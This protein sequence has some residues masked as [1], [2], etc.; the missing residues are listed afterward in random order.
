MMTVERRIT[1]SELG[2]DPKKFE[3]QFMYGGIRPGKDGRVSL[4]HIFEH[5]G[6]KYACPKSD[7]VWGAACY[8]FSELLTPEEFAQRHPEL[9]TYDTYDEVPNF[10]SGR[11]EGTA[12]LC[13]QRQATLGHDCGLLI[14]HKGKKYRLCPYVPGMQICTDDYEA[15]KKEYDAWVADGRPSY[16]VWVGDYSGTYGWSCAGHPRTEEE[17]LTLYNHHSQIG[18]TKSYPWAQKDKSLPPVVLLNPDGHIVS[19]HF[20]ADCDIPKF[21]QGMEY[22]MGFSAWTPQLQAEFMSQLKTEVAAVV[23]TELQKMVDEGTVEQLQPNPAE[24][25]GSAG[26]TDL[27]RQNGGDLSAV[28]REPVFGGINA[29]GWPNPLREA[30]E[31]RGEEVLDVAH[32]ETLNELIAYRTEL[33]AAEKLSAAPLD[34]TNGKPWAESKGGLK[35]LE[36]YKESILKLKISISD[37]LAAYHD[38]FG[39]LGVQIMCTRAGLPVPE[40]AAERKVEEVCTVPANQLSLFDDIELK[41]EPVPQMWLF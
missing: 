29:E 8:T 41:P 20:P 30:Y 3:D 28:K 6:K 23:H 15:K 17:A 2:L 34:P 33:E 18:W 32:E 26:D 25:G 37:T 39:N 12:E 9:A 14:S 31:E 11:P 1:L 5:E 36:S 22:F 7:S 27:M 24:T 40:W 16:C 13:S 19:A 38:W 10:A 35:R 21:V 4:K